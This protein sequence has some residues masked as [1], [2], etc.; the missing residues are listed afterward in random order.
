MT[1]SKPERTEEKV[2][3]PF[4][5]KGDIDI[6]RTSDWYSEGRAHSAGRSAMIPQYHPEKVE[7]YNK[8]PSCGKSKKELKDFLE[9]GQDKYIPHE[10]RIK[11]I[12]ESG[13]P[14][15]IKFS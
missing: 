10:E 13:M 2:K 12:K 11:R 1:R 15:E 14:T 6:I 4:C 7:I 3:C 5:G 9:S 8:C